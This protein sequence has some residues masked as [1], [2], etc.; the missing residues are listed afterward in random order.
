[1]SYSR[2]GWVALTESARWIRS[3]V[4]LPM[5]LTTATTSDPWRQRPARCGR[6]RHGSDR[7]RRPRCRRTSG[8]PV[9]SGRGYRLRTGPL[10]AGGPSR[11]R[12]ALGVPGGSPGPVGD[13]RTLR[14]LGRVSGRA[15]RQASPPA[16]R[17][18]RRG[19]PP[20]P[21]SR[22]AASRSATGSSS[23]WSPASSWRSSS[24][25]RAG[26]TT[27]RGLTV[28]G[29]HDDEHDHRGH[30]R[31]RQAA[32]PGQRRRGQGRLPGQH[33]DRGEHAEVLGGARP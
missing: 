17:R 30:G 24:S 7:R 8:R 29:G 6:P 32:G 25:S 9:A 21:S 3:S 31:R 1:M 15:Q 28:Q 11:H 26:A 20:R 12:A 19:W 13:P 4:V 5:A 14:G 18:G 2:G 33:Q 23:W 16:R 27:N 10:A 22:S